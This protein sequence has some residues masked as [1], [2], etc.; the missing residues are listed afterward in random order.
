MNI[1]KLIIQEKKIQSLSLF[2]T[3]CLDQHVGMLGI[4]FFF[5][6]LGNLHMYENIKVTT[7]AQ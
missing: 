1:I 6:K 2:V 7:Y 4:P 5:G 3:T